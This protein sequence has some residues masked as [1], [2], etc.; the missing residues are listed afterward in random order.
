MS[1]TT[2]I[3]IYIVLGVAVAGLFIAGLHRIASIL[4][5]ILGISAGNDLRKY[6]QAEAKAQQEHTKVDATEAAEVDQAETAAKTKH[7]QLTA[8]AAREAQATQGQIQ[9]A[10]TEEQLGTVVGKEISKAAAD[11][12]RWEALTRPPEDGWARVVF[13]AWLLAITLTGMLLISSY[14][15]ANAPTAA[16]KADVQRLVKSLQGC[17]LM[18]NKIATTLTKER[19]QCKARLKA[20]EKHRKIDSTKHTTQKQILTKRPPIGG[21]ILVGG[22]T[23][24]VGAVIGGV[25]AYSISSKTPALKP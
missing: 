14:A 19:K 17:R 11:Q 1:K 23:L 20:C 10:E 5:G 15:H 6:A 24:I 3:V 13:V 25:V 21:Y 9:T 12:A 7:D 4:T 18:G 22:I 2:K 8:L 16:H